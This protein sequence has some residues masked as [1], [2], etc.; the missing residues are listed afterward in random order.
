MLARIPGYCTL[1]ARSRP[2]LVCARCTCP[3]EADAMGRTSNRRNRESHPGPQAPS[4]TRRNC[5]GGIGS[6]SALNRAKIA[7]SSAGSISPASIDKS[8][9]TFIAAPRIC[10]S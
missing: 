2:S 9:P 3:I 10:A 8:C 4:S 5:A 1:I 6:A 7:A